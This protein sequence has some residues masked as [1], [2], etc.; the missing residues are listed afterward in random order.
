MRNVKK[1]NNKGVSLLELV[2]V[3]AI[4]TTLTGL[5]VPQFI[6]YVSEK[7]QTACV[8]HREAAVNICE[9]IVVGRYAT[10]T[11]L[12]GVQLNDVGINALPAAIPDEYKEA[13]RRHSECPDHGTMSI[14][15]VNGTIQC[16]CSDP[17]HASQDVAVDV[18]TW[19]GESI[20]RMDPPMSTVS[21]VEYDP[22][23]PDDPEDEDDNDEDEP[24][25]DV[26]NSYWP[27]PEDSRWTTMD[28]SSD[29]HIDIDVPS[30]L[31][32]IRTAGGSTV[33]YCAIDK[34]GTHKLSVYKSKAGD[35]S[36]YTFGSDSEAV[37]ITNGINYNVDS[38]AKAVENNPGMWVD[39]GKKGEIDKDDQFWISG[40]TIY[41]C[42]NGRRYIYFHQ[43][44]ELAKMPPE[45]FEGNKTGEGNWYYVGDS[46]QINNH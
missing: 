38:F 21:G 7:R 42:A 45:N 33:Y 43:G 31:F 23:D 8:E 29:A 27:Y 6:K 37:I 24:E 22:H 13:L 5:L 10:L 39:N 44:Q 16:V 20:A 15:V 32:P 36:A 14:R 19:S 46:D 12:N 4:M 9:K 25:E 30:G 2:V 18:T 34:N 3:I 17:S 11:E 35:P 41:T 40:G 28:S 1:T 26:T